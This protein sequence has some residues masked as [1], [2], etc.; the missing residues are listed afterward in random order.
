MNTQVNDVYFDHL[1]VSSLTVGKGAQ[2]HV[3][4]SSAASSLSTS[5][6]PEINLS[7]TLALDANGAIYDRGY[8]VNVQDDAASLVFGSGCTIDNLNIIGKQDDSGYTNV[9]I[10]VHSDSATVTGMQD[11]GDLNVALGSLTV[12]NAKGSVH[13][14]LLLNNAKLKLGEGANDI[15]AA[16][17]GAVCLENGAR[18][19]IG[20]TQQTLSANNEV[21]LSGTS[22]ITG[23]AEGSGL[24]LG[25]GVRVNYEDA[26]N[27][28]AAKMTV[29]QGTGITLNSKQAGSSLEISGSISGSGNINLT[30]PGTVTLAGSNAGFDGQVMVQQGSTLTLQ[31]IDTLLN[32]GVVLN[33]GAN[34]VLGAPD[35]V[36][37]NSLTLLNGSSLTISS[38]IGTG[39]PSD[40][41]AV[42]NAKQGVTFGQ[43]SENVVLNV[44]F[45]KSLETMTTYNIMTGVTSIDNLSFNV[46]HNGALLDDSQYKISLNSATGLLY[47]HTMMGNVW[48]GKGTGNGP[49]YWSTTNTDG[50]WSS[51]NGNYDGS[52]K[53]KA[54][55]FGDLDGGSGDVYVSGVVA[56]G[57]IYFVAGTTEYK[58]DGDG[59][60]AKGTNIHKVGAADVSLNLANNATADTALGNV[61]IQSGRLLLEKALAVAGTVT[62]D[63]IAELKVK[64]GTDGLKMVAKE[65]GSFN[66]TVS[67][68]EPG[69]SATLS[70]V[71]MDAA[72]IRGME[73]AGAYIS[74][75]KLLVQGNA[76]LSHLTL[77]DF[78][79]EGDVTLSHVRLTSSTGTNSHDLKDVTIGKG[80]VVAP[81]ASYTLSGNI[82]FEDKL[83]N[84]GT[85]ILTDTTHVEIGKIKYETAIDTTSG[86]SKYVY[87]FISSAENADLQASEF[88]ADRVSINGINLAT[89]LA[90]G[91]VTGLASGIKVD[92]E[93]NGK[94]SLTVSIDDGSVGMPQ[95]D[96]RWCKSENAPALSRRYYVG[97]INSNLE[98]AKQ[99]DGYKYSSIVSGTNAAKVNNGKAI[100]V[101]LSSIA[102]GN[103]VV[104]GYTEKVDAGEVGYEVWIDD[105]S[106]FKN[107]Y[108]FKNIIGGLANW[109]PDWEAVIAQTQTGATHILVNSE[110]FID[111]PDLDPNKKVEYQKSKLW[112]KHFIIGGSRWSNQGKGWR[113]EDGVSFTL[114]QA[115]ESFVTVQ[116]G[117][118]YNIFGGSCGG[119]Y[120]IDD[121]N[122]WG[123]ISTVDVTQ[124]GTS[125]VFVDG[126]T[127]GEIFAG[128]YCANIKGSQEVNGRIRAVEMVLTGGTLGGKNLRV[129]GGT[130]HA[131]VD[132]DIYVRMEGD[133]NISSRLVGGSN[134]GTVN[135]NIV[136]DLISGSAFRVDAAGLGWQIEAENYYD[137]ARIN[138]EVLV[139]LYRDFH[140][141]NGADG[142]LKSGIYGGMEMSN[143]VLLTGNC[144]S[145][146]H[147]AESGTYELGFIGADGYSTSEDSII[148]TGFDRFIMEDGAHAMLGLGKFDIDMDPNKTLSIEGKGIVEVIG[149]GENFGRNI[150]LRDSATLK[151]S[152][153]VIGL[154]TNDDDRTI[155][156]TEGSTIDFSGFPLG[157]LY[158]GDSDY[159]G[160]GFKVLICGDGVDGMGALYKGK[161]EGSLYPKDK[162]TTSSIVNRIVLPNVE[163]TG[164][165]SLKVEEQEILFMNAYELGET[166]LNLAGYT[167]TKLG[168][169]DFIA[170]SVKMTK[171][172][173]LVQQGAFGFDLTDTAAQTDMVLATGSEL[174]L[175]ATGLK[176]ADTSGLVLRSLS[177]SGI[178]NLNGSTLTLHTEDGYGYYDEYMD[179]EQSYDQFS[180]TTGFGYA[181]F[182]GLLS[183]G[184]SAGGKLVKVGSGV[185]YI[186]GSSNTYTGGTQLQG[187]RLYLLGTGEASEFTKGESTVASGVA[188]TG[189]IVWGSTD[190][191]LYLGHGAH[192][193][194][195]GTTNVQGGGEM[196]IGVEGVL[197][198]VLADFVGIHSK[199][200]GGSLTYVTMGGENYVEIETHNLKSLNVNAQYADGTEYVAGTDIDRNKMLLVKVSDWEAV[201]NTAVN[202]IGEAGYNEAIYSGVLQDSNGKSAKLHKVGVG[203]LVLDQSNSYTGGTEIEAGTL[204]LR[205]WGTLGKNE[206]ENAVIVQKGATL[207]FTHNSGYG[208]EPTRANN[209]ITINGTGDARWVGHAA[210]DGGTAALIS[211]VGPA[212]TFT[213]SGDISG[214]GNVR[215]S[216]EGVLVLS[217]DS[218]YTGG[219]YVSRGTVEVQSATGL[220]ATASGQS[221]VTIERDA[222]LR[223]TVESG[224]TGNRMVT[225]LAADVN[226][227]QGDIFIAGTTDTERILHM[228]GNGYK[229]LST[230]LGE[231]GMLLVNGAAINGVAVMA[232]SEQLTG[233]G[234]VVVSDASA[235][236]ASATFKSMIDYNGDFRVEGDKASIS[237]K[238]G[239]FID[240]SIHVAGQ[241][242][243]V[244]IGSD[245][246]IADGESLHLISTGDASLDTAAIV[247]TEGSVSIEAGATLSVRKEATLY[248][249]DLSKLRDAASFTM[250]ENALL[251]TPSDNLPENVVYRQLG[252]D[253]GTYDGRFDA[254]VAGNLQAVGVV[255]ANGESGL[256]LAGGATYETVNA[257]TCLMGGS[258]T[259]DTMEKSLLT[260]NTTS[261]ISFDASTDGQ[262]VL[263]SGVDSV[264]FGYDKVTVSDDSGIVY[265]LANRYITGCDFIHDNTLLVFDSYA[266]VVYLQQRAIP[267]PATVTLSL[268]ALA[269][270]AARRRRK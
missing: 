54:A 195:N 209:D 220:G 8:T 214:S 207:M 14:E 194:N 186:S 212:V 131:V 224:F 247:K 67:A 213:L 108:G 219:T 42:L 51:G 237:V 37:L 148:V 31:N 2:V 17:S 149:H 228:D 41:Y 36:Q 184:S 129:F 173:V 116:N 63:E 22:S 204:R 99:A 253:A 265:T 19:D 72:G 24:L 34:L 215:H 217:G 157:T 142:D 155:T 179:D 50:N 61:D 11:L 39:A 114:E 216:G 55:I 236:G 83:T 230:T 90:T 120:N 7:G 100:A 121:P 115:A 104:G 66:Y 49:R 23:A 85:V 117:Q 261:D 137:P 248:E 112:A 130:D 238:A 222:D 5:T 47:M 138:G 13:G 80:V 218:S 150:I 171:G 227:I 256:T 208:D 176:I 188:G 124:Y 211:A 59:V 203:T 15:M 133:A 234:S 240:G 229:A 174:K 156:V 146:L 151:I 4:T 243:S 9:G 16:N 123:K 79:A 182:S 255:Q 101:T 242:A 192:I 143:L 78:E 262:L 60:L 140:L 267:E 107:I 239:T 128:G 87:Q 147:F 189:S 257:H 134:A 38:I 40:K 241:Q 92:F 46:L 98:I 6:L 154:T 185:H 75:D 268:L 64:G 93:D 145:S 1:R 74:A 200:Q 251:K 58:L 180:G 196:I 28:I 56:P 88:T 172:T 232:E 30:G 190:A 43:D 162:D 191:E 25:D 89:N 119:K 139:N 152:T 29:E 18:L 65:G 226:D 153:S 69:S 70:G 82:T 20:K 113:N 177:G 181:V 225:K 33:T 132:G 159:A 206:K 166:H 68:I 106:G 135:G 76:H 122:D 245:I 259:L 71:T 210:T 250:E 52:G 105:R 109:T 111:N 269:G 160:L 244:Y 235:S 125:H 183:D 175:N 197:N 141:G 35:A 127:I 249:Y 110:A 91:L 270:L 170:R 252:S 187:G 81:S 44:I 264:Y 10:K 57:D 169:G 62:I 12:K 144:T 84:E 178:V 246:F 193:Y 233:S 86:K 158:Q 260:F 32:A 136:L 161:Y 201:K 199:G 221:S 165:A 118:I 205:G 231:N 167:L 27:S 102:K 45:S 198:G 266:N 53:Y 77:N 73:G 95:W 163:L 21:S 258:L 97:T 96:E 48:D 126:G 26:G 168:A 3:Q 254:S 202:G 263:F 94:G 164:S 223:F 103:L